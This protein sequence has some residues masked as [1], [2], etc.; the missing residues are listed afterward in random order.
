M[1]DLKSSNKSWTDVAFQYTL[2]VFESLRRGDL[3]KSCERHIEMYKQTCH[4][5]FPLTL[6]FKP[7]VLN[8]NVDDVK[9][10]P[11]DDVDD[12]TV[13]S[14]C[15]VTKNIECADAS[16]GDASPVANGAAS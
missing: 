6:A 8:N 5:M 7:P 10:T 9:A 16:A 14:S 4:A 12:V 1:A 2:E 13:P 3:G 15:P 11:E